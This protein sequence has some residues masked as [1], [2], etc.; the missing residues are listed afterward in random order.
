M[1]PVTALSSIP[2]S[3]SDALKDLSRATASSVPAATMVP[4]AA[5]TPKVAASSAAA[6]D[7]KSDAA[8]A[9]SDYTVRTSF[10]A[11]TGEWALVV[12]RHPPEVGVIVAEQKGFIS[13]YS[14]MANSPMNLN[15]GY[16]AQV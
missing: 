8:T 1:S 6:S 3:S 13:Q 2:S 14:A 9:T 4:E 10:D 12:E 11:A 15:S 16:I 5:A 7:T